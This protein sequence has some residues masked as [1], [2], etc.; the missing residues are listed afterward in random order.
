[1]KHAVVFNMGSVVSS[2]TNQSD[3]IEEACKPLLWDNDG[4]DEA[5]DDLYYR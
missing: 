3:W 4:M 1:M 5:D 2:S